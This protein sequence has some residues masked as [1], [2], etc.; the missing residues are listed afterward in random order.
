MELTVSCYR[1]GL[2]PVGQSS[3]LCRDFSIRGQIYARYGIHK[4]RVGIIYSLYIPKVQHNGENHR[5]YY[6]TSVVWLRQTTPAGECR[7]TNYVVQGVTYSQDRDNFKLIPGTLLAAKADG[8]GQ[9][10]HPIIGYD[11]GLDL[12]PAQ[13]G[14]KGAL[15][16]PMIGWT[17]LS[18][19]A[20]QQFD[21]IK[22]EHAKCPFNDWNFLK[23]LEAAY[24]EAIF[25]GFAVDAGCEKIPDPVV[26]VPPVT[27]AQPVTP[28]TPVSFT[29]PAAT[30]SNLPAYTEMGNLLDYD[31]PWNNDDP[32]DPTETGYPDMVIPPEIR[33][34]PPTIAPF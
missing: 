2:K 15:D 27:P 21:G 22:Y 16:M 26:D 9:L 30:T 4:G 3:G 32:T 28:A 25:A 12:F 7:A 5:H 34:P 8:Q 19:P 6:L 20:K 14:V 23:T 17:S 18:D 11:G 10:T 24:D 13:N 33:L 31:D 1:A 29:P